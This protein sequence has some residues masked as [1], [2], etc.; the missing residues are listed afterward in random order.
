MIDETFTNDK[1]KNA[2]KAILMSV[3]NYS[4]FIRI[5]FTLISYL[6]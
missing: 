2:L 5:L 1:Y 4:S 3:I 6:L